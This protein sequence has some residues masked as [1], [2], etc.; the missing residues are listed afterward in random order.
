MDE[1]ALMMYFLGSKVAVD[2]ETGGLP[3]ARLQVYHH[4]P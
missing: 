1:W 2:G 3:L 4:L